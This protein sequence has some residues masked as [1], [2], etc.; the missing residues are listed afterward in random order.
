MKRNIALDILKLSMALMIVGLHA[1]FLGDI[2]SLGSFLTVN[3]IFRIAVPVFFLINGFYFYPVLLKYSH[4]NWFKRVFILHVFWTVFY[5]YFWLNNPDFPFIIILLKNIIIGYYHL[6]YIPAMLGAGF[7]VF[8]A[9]NLS[10]LFLVFSVLLTFLC[11]VLIQY[12]ATYHLLGDN[13][14][15]K[16]LSYQFIYRNLLFFAYPFFC[17]G[18]LINKH[19]LHKYFSFK[20]ILIVIA[21]GVIA[22]ITE[23]YLNYYQSTRDGGFDMFFSLIIL[24]P[25]ILILFLKINIPNESKKIALYST[26]IYFIHLFI[27]NLYREYT[28]L[29]GTL[30]TL[31]TIVSSVFFSYFI[32]KLNKRLKFIL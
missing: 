28:E 20:L 9:K 27:L 2:T 22:L 1:G 14:L 21:I 13:S 25:F 23:S 6:W 12:T 11:G 10:S 15:D 5:S 17:L 16:I 8:L 32:I 18:F 24:C 3:G 26:S 31:T 30:L 29:N 19:L 7:L 4:V